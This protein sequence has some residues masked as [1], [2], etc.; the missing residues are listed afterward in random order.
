MANSNNN[1]RA[2]RYD[3]WINWEELAEMHGWTGSIEDFKKVP[4][5][6]LPRLRRAA[7]A[8]R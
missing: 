5:E 4:V 7:K 3:V 6:E 8:G 2:S 1:D